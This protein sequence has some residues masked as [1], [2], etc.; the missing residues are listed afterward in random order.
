MEKTISTK[1]PKFYSEFLQKF[2]EVGQAYEKLGDAIYQQSLLNERERALIKL[3]IS[4]SHMFHSAL[5]AHIRKASAAGVSKEHMEQVALLMLPT[6]GFPTMM[7]MLG[8]IEEQ[9]DKQRGQ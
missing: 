1:P 5:K 4:G 7:T 8:V 6:V 9:L 2:P 3:A